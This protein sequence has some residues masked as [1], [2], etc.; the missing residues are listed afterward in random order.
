MLRTQGR[1]LHAEFV[2]LLPT[3]PRPIRMQRFSARR[4]GLWAATLALL[5]LAALNTKYVFNTED[6][7]ETPLGRNDVGCGDLEPLWLLAQSVPSA[8][9]VPCVQLLPV[10]WKVAEV[11]VNSGRSV[12]AVDHDRAGKRAVVVRLTS[13]CDLAGATEVTSEQPGARRYLRIDHDAPGFSATRA[14]AFPGGCITERISA[15]AASGRQLTTETSSA[16]GFISRE[17]LRQ[18]LSQRSDGRLQLDPGGSSQGR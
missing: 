13:S 2:R 18:A 16:I 5:V 12:L 10:G 4:L 6:L 17:E 3:P 14:Y 7:V 9:L 11:A 8:S 15:P 1:D